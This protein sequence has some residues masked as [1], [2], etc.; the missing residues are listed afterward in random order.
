M[1]LY[2]TIF[3]K[4]APLGGD[5][6]P[7]N[8]QLDRTYSLIPYSNIYLRDEMLFWAASAPAFTPRRSN[9]ASRN[10]FRYLD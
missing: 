2:A 3:V 4:T 5:H 9:Y 7:T 8:G 1:D 10:S 6:H